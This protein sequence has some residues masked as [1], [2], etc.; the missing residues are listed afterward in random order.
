ME[1]G[2]RLDLTSEVFPTSAIL[3]MEKCWEHVPTSTGNA[4]LSKKPTGHPISN[5]PVTSEG[6]APTQCPARHPNTH[7]AQQHHAVPPPL[8]DPTQKPPREGGSTG[9]TNGDRQM[10]GHKIGRLGAKPS[11]RGNPNHL[12]RHTASS[13]RPVVTV[14]LPNGLFFQ[15]GKKK[16]RGLF[17]E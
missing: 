15:K 12:H 3:W 13:T 17:G 10:L 9:R 11:C 4:A 14:Q 7:T 1:L 8:A 2:Q 6:T 16:K 5:Y